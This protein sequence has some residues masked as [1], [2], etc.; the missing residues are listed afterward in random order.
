[1]VSGEY[2]EFFVGLAG[3]AGAL[4]GLLFV[5]L[6]LSPRSTATLANP[7]VRQVRASAALIAFTNTLAVSLF[8][9]VPDTNVGYPA[10]VMGVVGLL[11]TAAG[12]RSLL[13]SLSELRARLHQLGLVILLVL[14]FGVELVCGVLVIAGHDPATAMHLIG[15]AL[16]TSVLA[17][18]ARAWEMVGDRDTGLYAS[19]A[20]LLEHR[21]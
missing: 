15:Y 17:G 11:F 7:V 2:R 14:I 21:P 12:V 20:K 10:A 5:A 9:L 19:I 13:T 1:M 16:V 6:S 4:T 3:A 18:V 8:G